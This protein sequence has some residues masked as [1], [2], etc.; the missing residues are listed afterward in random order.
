MSLVDDIKTQNVPQ[1]PED[2]GLIILI[3]NIFISGAGTIWAGVLGNHPNTKTIGIIQLVLYILGYVFSWT[4]VGA[5]LILIGWIWAIW[6]GF[7]IY[8][9]SKG[10]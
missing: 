9:K 4:G 1:V 6:W 5:I 2:K 3:L 7:L 8:K 10:G